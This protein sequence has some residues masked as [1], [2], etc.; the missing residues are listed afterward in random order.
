MAA[1]AAASLNRDGVRHIVVVNRTPDRAAHLAA[2]YGG[3][4]APMESLARSVAEADL[5]VTCTGAQSYVLDASIVS[6]GS[7]GRLALVDLALPRDVD[8][9][10]RQIP[11]IHLVDLERVAA[12]GSVRAAEVAQETDAVRRIVLAEVEAFAAG[13]RAEAVAPT[14]AALRVMAADVV[15]AELDRL[16]GKTPELDTKE[17]AEVEQAV[18]R[19]VDKLLHVPT[20]RVKQLAGSPGG[21]S[22]AEALRELFGLDPASVEAVEAIEA[23]ESAEH[24]EAVASEAAGTTE[25]SR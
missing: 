20:V 22:Y 6:V 11:G 9:A 7:S 8:P 23:V 15:A 2:Q 5:V 21:A 14:V 10:V 24:V 1:L 16:R 13:Q 4:A 19:V 12:D 18:R 3:A 25:E 17:R